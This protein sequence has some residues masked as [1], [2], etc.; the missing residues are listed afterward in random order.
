MGGGG[1]GPDMNKMMQGMGMVN[2]FPDSKKKIK[3][4]STK[5]DKTVKWRLKIPCFSRRI[6]EISS[7]LL[8]KISLQIIGLH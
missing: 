1:R 2:Y 6:I 7:T 8:I 5:N 3:M 4:S